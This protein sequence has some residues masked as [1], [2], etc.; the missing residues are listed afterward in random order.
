[1][2]HFR[3]V[4]GWIINKLWNMNVYRRDETLFVRCCQDTTIRTFNDKSPIWSG[5]ELLK[6][7]HDKICVHTALFVEEKD[8]TK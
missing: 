7:H 2:R 5:L 1:M 3:P 8:I 4:K 6:M